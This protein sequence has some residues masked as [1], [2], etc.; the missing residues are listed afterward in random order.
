MDSGPDLIKM[1]E[2]EPDLEPRIRYGRTLFYPTHDGRGHLDWLPKFASTSRPS[3]RNEALQDFMVLITNPLWELLGGPCQRCGDYYLK[4]TKRQKA[5]CSRSCSSAATA[6]PAV[7]RQ[8]QQEHAEKIRRA[9][10][11]IEKWSKAKRTLGWKDWVINHTG[12]KLQ[13]I[14]RA[15]NNGRL[16]PPDGAVS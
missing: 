11:A 7:T 3:Y 9:Q 4:K 8:R 10:A 2:K 6:V 12:Y 16:R 15:V 5:Y 1:F 13:W 14:T